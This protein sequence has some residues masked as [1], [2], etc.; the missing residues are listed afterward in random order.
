M[1]EKMNHSRS[2][3]QYPRKS[4]NTGQMI[5]RSDTE[6]DDLWAHMGVREDQEFTEFRVQ[7]RTDR[8]NYIGKQQSIDNY[9]RYSQE[10][11]EQDSEFSP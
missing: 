4:D 6:E 8:N 10:N 11:E 3:K 7:E 2:S 1:T 9:D 5:K